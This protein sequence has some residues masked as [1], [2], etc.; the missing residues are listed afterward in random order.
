MGRQAGFLM[1]KRHALSFLHYLY[2]AVHTGSLLPKFSNAKADG[3]PTYDWRVMSS[4]QQATIKTQ[5]CMKM[6]AGGGE[7]QDGALLN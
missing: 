2:C 4:Q 1:H 3:S 6:S 7:F 5:K